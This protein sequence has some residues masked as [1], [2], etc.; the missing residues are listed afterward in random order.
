MIE[1]IHP[2]IVRIAVTLP[3]NPLRELNCY[4]ICGEGRNLLIDTGFNRPECLE[5]LQAGLRE[6]NL[7]MERTDLFLTHLHSDHVGL[8]SQ[9][10]APGSRIY[11]NSI[12]KG[13]MDRQLA[14][15]EGWEE[16]AQ[17]FLADG[18]PPEELTLVQENNPGRKYQS[19][20]ILTTLPVEDGTRL[21]VGGISLKCVFTPGHTPGHTC[22]YW[23][24]EQILFSG[25]HVLFDITPN[26]SIW[27]ILPDPLA[28][29]FTSLGKVSKLP[30][31]LCLPGHRAKNEDLNGRIRSLL[32]H[33]RLRLE[34][35][36]HLVEAQPGI[37]GYEVAR[38]MTWSIRAKGWEDFPVGQKWF[39]VGEAM[40]HLAFLVN[41]GALRKEVRNG[42]SAYLPGAAVDLAAAIDA[43]FCGAWQGE[44]I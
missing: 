40:T 44:S 23:E 12:D 15:P 26:I 19:S 21:D 6:M 29:Y 24:E 35:V 31:K 43:R 9:V 2:N 37:S 14:G 41:L 17:S 16:Q 11:M 4:V 32:H 33:H 18:F 34:E 42:I 7:D 13:W 30:T 36:V 39:A 22:L 5:A 20:H 10:A 28:A 1:Q 38:K 27:S 25:D 3:Q 8:A